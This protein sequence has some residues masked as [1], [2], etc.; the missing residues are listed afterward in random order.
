MSD[1]CTSR[2]AHL[3]RLHLKTKKIP[4]KYSIMKL[5][6]RRVKK[7]IARLQNAALSR[8]G[9]ISIFNIQSIVRGYFKGNIYLRIFLQDLNFLKET[10]G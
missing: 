3:K 10:D 1:I 8:V 5:S 9:Q 7:N 2:D 6:K 4:F